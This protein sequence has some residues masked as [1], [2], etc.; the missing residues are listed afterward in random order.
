MITRRQ[1]IEGAA[2]AGVSL[3]LPASLAGCGTQGAEDQST[4]SSTASS[5]SETDASTSVS[6]E[7]SSASAAS[8]NADDDG[9]DGRTDDGSGTASSAAEQET[10]QSASEEDTVDT[11]QIEVNGQ[12]FTGAL[13]T[14]EAAQEFARR[15]PLTLDMSELS[16]NEKYCKTGQDFPGEDEFPSSLHAGEVWIYAGDYVVL[17]YED[18]TNPGYQYQ[19]VGSLDDATGLAEAVG[20][21]SVQV[22][23]S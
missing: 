15:L 10:E 18:H 23:F 7:S 8:S 5:S 17:F 20:S 9:S 21:G 3:V 22:T 4:S 12:T 2:L 11:F 19:Y 16:G 6:E 13:G 1:F 14:T